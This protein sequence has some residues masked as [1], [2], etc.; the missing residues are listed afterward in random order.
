M[1]HYIAKA[2]LFGPLKRFIQAQCHEIF[3]LVFQF[4]S[5]SNPSGTLIL[6]LEYFQIYFLD[7]VEIIAYAKTILRCCWHC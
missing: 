6:K 2:H 3:T 7:F 1:S 4:F 5:N